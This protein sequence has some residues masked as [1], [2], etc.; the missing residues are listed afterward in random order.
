MVRRIRTRVRFFL[1]ILAVISSGLPSRRTNISIAVCRCSSEWTGNQ[2]L[3]WIFRAFLIDTQ[4]FNF[5]QGCSQHGSD[6]GASL[7][8]DVLW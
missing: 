4:A 3:G 6:H 7:R 1:Q 8:Y 2:R 5:H